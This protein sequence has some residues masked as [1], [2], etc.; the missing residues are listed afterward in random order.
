ML[1]RKKELNRIAAEF[2][3]EKILGKL[4]QFVAGS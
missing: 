1:K 3:A 2:G 4:Y